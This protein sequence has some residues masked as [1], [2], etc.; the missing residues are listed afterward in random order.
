VEA[1]IAVQILIVLQIIVFWINVKVA[2]SAKMIIVLVL[3]VVMTS[4]AKLEHA[5]MVFV[6]IAQI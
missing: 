1:K 2:I 4:N 5:W 6:K 3:S